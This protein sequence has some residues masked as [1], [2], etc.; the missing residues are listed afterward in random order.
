MGGELHIL[1]ESAQRL[2][3]G[4]KLEAG[5]GDVGKRQKQAR[6]NEKVN[7]ERLKRDCAALIRHERT[8]MVR[9]RSLDGAMRTTCGHP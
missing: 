3:S 9:E 6:P 2:P 4:Y 8:F 7:D 1:T 5:G